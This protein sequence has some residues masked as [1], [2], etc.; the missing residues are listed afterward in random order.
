M[1]GRRALCV[2]LSL[3]AAIARQD[4]DGGHRHSQHSDDGGGEFHP[5][6]GPTERKINTDVVAEAS[7]EV[8][9][10]RGRMATGCVRYIA[11]I[12]T[13]PLGDKV[14]GKRVVP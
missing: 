1:V 10:M 13:V 5:Y 4:R 14:H 9:S 6:P 12:D 8:Q 3:A 11:L 2:L 7:R